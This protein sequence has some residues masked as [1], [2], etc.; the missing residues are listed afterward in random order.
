MTLAYKFIIATIHF[1][2]TRPSVGVAAAFLPKALD[3]LSAGE[4]TIKLIGIYLGFGIA[5]L[6]FAIKSFDFAQRINR[7]LIRR[8]AEKESA[9]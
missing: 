2:S 8:K 3:W 5:L 6:T 9:L 4:S 1:L 7:W